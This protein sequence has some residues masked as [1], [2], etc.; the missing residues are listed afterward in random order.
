M[1]VDLFL[2]CSTGLQLIICL[3]EAKIMGLAVNL[4]LIRFGHIILALGDSLLKLC[5]LLCLSLLQN[6]L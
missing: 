3:I 1:A 4:I 6:M 5:F 2:G